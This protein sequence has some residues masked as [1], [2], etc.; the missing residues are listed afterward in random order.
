MGG[1]WNFDLGCGARRNH[2]F[3]RPHPTSDTA[4]EVHD[5][6]TSNATI[7]R[8]DTGTQEV[9]AVL[10]ESAA[11][12]HPSSDD[13]WVFV[14]S[15]GNSKS[16]HTE[17]P[18]QKS[19]ARCARRRRLR[20]RIALPKRYVIFGSSE[21]GIPGRNIDGGRFVCFLMRFRS[22]FPSPPL[23]AI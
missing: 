12:G 5:L 22:L 14:S 8:Y 2:R 23:H 4:F 6:S 18:R 19:T 7:R 9:P 21:R 15:I 16:C 1:I 3:I 13:R 10:M 20:W 17:E 11:A